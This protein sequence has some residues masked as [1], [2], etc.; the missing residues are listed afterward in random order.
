MWAVSRRT[1]LFIVSYAPL[2]AM[3]L[4]LKWP[5]GWTAVELLHL[6]VWIVSIAALLLLPSLVV[7]V[8][9]KVARWVVRVGLVAAIGGAV[10]GPVLGWLAPLALSPE[11]PATAATAAGI[12]FGFCVLALLIVALLLYNA[13]RAGQ[14]RWTVSDQR[15]QGGAVTGYL[16]TYLLPLLSLSAGGWRVTTAYGIYLAT[17][18]VIYIRSEGLVLINP[19]LYLFGYRI[20]DVEVGADHASDRRR[21]LLLTKLH[22]TTK[23]EVD[24]VPLGDQ[25]YLASA[26]GQS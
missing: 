23:M 12:A 26:S 6:A 14:V 13:R 11:E 3:F 2:A 4:A 21:V 1:G 18:Y 22:I 9:G 5:R 8:T 7:A 19:T 15:D 25:C 20:Y 10:L 16:A 24:V 17:L